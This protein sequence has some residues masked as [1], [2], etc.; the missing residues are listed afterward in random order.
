MRQILSTP[1]DSNKHV[2]QASPE[3][4]QKEKASG[5]GLQASG[6]PKTCCLMP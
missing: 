4:E 2:I 3:A 5:Y 1:L 6:K